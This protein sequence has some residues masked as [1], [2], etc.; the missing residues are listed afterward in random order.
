MSLPKENAA[1]T[2]GEG[3]GHLNTSVLLALYTCVTR[4]F[5]AI[6]NQD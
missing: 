5:Q 4:G 2:S 6:P 3:G 1:G